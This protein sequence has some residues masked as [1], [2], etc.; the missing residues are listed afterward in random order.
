MAKFTSLVW[1]NSIRYRESIIK[2]TI[3]MITTIT[4]TQGELSHV[5][6]RTSWNII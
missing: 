1:V 5:D 4:G 6:A 3:T 2:T